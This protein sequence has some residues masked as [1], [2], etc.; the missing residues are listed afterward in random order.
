MCVYIFVSACLGSGAGPRGTVRLER[1]HGSLIQVRSCSNRSLFIT[2]RFVILNM[3]L[4]IV[5]LRMFY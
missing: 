3:I 1:P 4:Y 5:E 2:E